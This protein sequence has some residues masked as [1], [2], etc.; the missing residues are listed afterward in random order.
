MLHF[1]LVLVLAARFWTIASHR[2]RTTA[3][4]VLGVVEGSHLTIS[5]ILHAKAHMSTSLRNSAKSVQ[6]RMKE[7]VSQLRD[8]VGYVVLRAFRSMKTETLDCLQPLL[9]NEIH[10]LPRMKTASSDMAQAVVD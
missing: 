6:E 2:S 10:V 3:Q 7:R 8:V 5:Q 9:S 4:A 1:S